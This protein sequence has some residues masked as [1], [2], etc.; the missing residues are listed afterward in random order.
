VAS[1]GEK[2]GAEKYNNLPEEELRKECEK[3]NLDLDGAFSKEDFIDLL[4]QDDKKPTDWGIVYARLLDAG[5]R[6]DEIP[7]RTLP[8]IT[9]LLG[10]WGN[11]VSIKVGMPNIFGSIGGADATIPTDSNKQNSQEDVDSFFNSF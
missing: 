11:I 10:E 2:E 6:Y 4:V 9:A 8:Q 3:R 5:L 7:Q 1:S